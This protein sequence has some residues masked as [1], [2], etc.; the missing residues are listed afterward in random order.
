MCWGEFIKCV[1]DTEKIREAAIQCGNFEKAHI[2]RTDL[3][4]KNLVGASL[5]DAGKVGANFRG[6]D[7]SRAN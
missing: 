2:R 3:W 6:D 7:L 5:I 1:F 4:F